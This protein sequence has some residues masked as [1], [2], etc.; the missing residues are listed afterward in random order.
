V[1]DENLKE[2]FILDNNTYD[3]TIISPTL[4]DSGVYACV[5]DSGMGTQH[6]TQLHVIEENDRI[7]AQIPVY[8]W[9]L[10]ALGFT[11]LI[12]AIVLSAY[13]FKRRQT[14][15]NVDRKSTNAGQ[16]TTARRNSGFTKEE[17]STDPTAHVIDIPQTSIR[18]R[19]PR[20]SKDT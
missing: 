4:H 18:N 13:I 5:E 8:G 20:N 6:Q 11:L 12:L 10:L 17:P 3:L 14:T 2:R 16:P 9:I 1:L 19:T 15:R 7:I